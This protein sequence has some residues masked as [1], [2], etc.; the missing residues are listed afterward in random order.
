MPI[1]MARNKKTDALTKKNKKGK[2]KRKNKKVKRQVHVWNG[3]SLWSGVVK[4]SP[5]SQGL[6]LQYFFTLCFR[7]IQYTAQYMSSCE[8]C[9]WWIDKAL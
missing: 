4:C 9:L 8:M 5:E 3:A 7:S 6:A 1:L 2:N